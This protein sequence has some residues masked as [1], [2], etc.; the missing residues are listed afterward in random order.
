MYMYSGSFY[1]NDAH[2]S[3]EIYFCYISKTGRCVQGRIIDKII[4]I[5]AIML[6]PL[7]DQRRSK[8]LL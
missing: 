6:H 3:L 2:S 7:K 8:T 4:I 1:Y 5:K